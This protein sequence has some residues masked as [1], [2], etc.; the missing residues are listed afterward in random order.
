[1][2]VVHGARS[3]KYE[4]LGPSRAHALAALKAMLDVDCVEVATMPLPTFTTYA[5]Y[6]PEMIHV[7]PRPVVRA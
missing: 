1:M 7:C 4:G 5:S 2:T 3:G 6:N